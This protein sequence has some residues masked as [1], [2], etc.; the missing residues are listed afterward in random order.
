MAPWGG[1]GEKGPM[2]RLLPWTLK[3]RRVPALPAAS[4]S[5][6]GT[7]C[8]FSCAPSGLCLLHGAARRRSS[9]CAHTHPYARARASTVHSEQKREENVPVRVFELYQRRSNKAFASC[10]YF[11]LNVTL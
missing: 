3:F 6:S 8:G 2:E 7:F 10:L 11:V 5:G 4:R 9:A 1:K